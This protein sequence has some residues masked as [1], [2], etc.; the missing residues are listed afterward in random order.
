MRCDDCGY[1]GGR[2]GLA[3]RR[4]FWLRRCRAGKA[5]IMTSA[6][7]WILSSIAKEY[8]P[9]SSHRS[10]ALQSRFCRVLPSL[11][12]VCSQYQCFQS[13]QEEGPSH[14]HSSETLTRDATLPD[15]SGTRFRMKIGS[16]R[17]CKRTHGDQVHLNMTN[18]ATA[19]TVR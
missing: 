13:S 2:V 3:L 5:D 9:P 4:D 15:I 16:V 18:V 19:C 6:Y 8:R 10:S 12:K 7:R 17:D 1:S 11:N 14:R